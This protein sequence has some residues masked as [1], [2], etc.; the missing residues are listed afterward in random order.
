MF[1]FFNK[2]A[3]WRPAALLNKKL[4]LS[5]FPVSFVEFLRKPIY[6]NFCERLLLQEQTLRFFPGI[7]GETSS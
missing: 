5:C 4:L 7:Y 1:F 2:I 6:R 3:D